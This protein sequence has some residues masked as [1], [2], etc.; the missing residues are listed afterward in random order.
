MDRIHSL[1]MEAVGT[2][3][4]RQQVGWD[5]EVS[6]E[7]LSQVLALAREHHV[8]PLVFETVHSCPAASQLD[9]K[10]FRELQK[11]TALSVM[12]QAA[13]SEEFLQL[14][15]FLRERDLTP[16][17]VKGLICRQLY[18]CPDYRHSGDED[19]LCG[20][21]AFQA[22]HQ[23]LVAWGM[24]PSQSSMDSYEVSY[25]KEDSA[26]H[27]ELH[28]TLFAT[29]S[30]VLSEYNHLF[31]H[32]LTHPVEVLVAGV[33]VATL[34]WSE[35]LLYLLLHAFKHFLH[36]G[37]GIR[38]VCDIVLFANAYGQQINWPWLQDRCRELRA[39]KF[40]AAIFRI[41]KEHLGFSPRQAHYPQGWEALSVDAQPLL[42]DLLQ[43]GIYGSADRSRVHS[44]NM[45][46]NAVAS[47]K[48]GKAARKSIL[49]TIFP[50]ASN[51]EGRFPW[52]GRRPWLLPVAWCCRIFVYTRETISSPAGSA[53]EVIRTGSR[54]VELL[55]H[56]DIID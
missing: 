14:Y 41:G 5:E 27:I 13:K 23:A 38:Q 28:K 21:E 8:L 10:T 30:K 51:L 26:L 11:A 7:E 36:S 4:K 44:S 35:H 56:Y 24:K 2:A 20:K 53:A 18:P 47:S 29:N 43:G 32:S 34:E 52:L 40:A 49:R 54:R 6:L 42:E 48:K 19:V 22:C 33:P 31:E 45:T 3:L 46:L 39:E 50:D 55:R 15:T 25:R 9:L 1:F 17:V 12:T 37:F 16:L